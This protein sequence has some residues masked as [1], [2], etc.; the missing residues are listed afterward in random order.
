[1]NTK[2]RPS[3]MDALEPK[4]VWNFFAGISAVPRPSKKEEKI[5][6]YVKELAGSLHLPVR[7]D[8]SGNLCLSVAA[9]PGFEHVPATV[10]QGHLDMVCEK[11]SGTDH[12]F[13]RD[14]IHLVVDE[15]A[16]DGGLFVRAEGTTLGADNGIGVALALAAATSPEV[17]HG[18]LEILCTI[19]EETGMTGAIGL[20]PDFFRGRRMLNLDSD[21]DEILYVGCAGGCDA[22]LHWDLPLRPVAK[23]EEELHIEVS[24]LRGGHSG[25]DVHEDRGNA[26]LLVVRSLLQ[27]AEM[28]PPI[29]D[30]PSASSWPGVMPFRLVSFTGGSKRNAIAR[31]ARAVVAAK[32]GATERLLSV[33]AKLQEETIREAGE[34]ACSI[35]VTK[36]ASANQAGALSAEDSRR[37]LLTLEAVP[38]GVLAIVPEIP[39]LVR[40][41]N[42]VATLLWEAGSGSVS[43]TL[44]CLAR[45][46][47]SVQI[48]Q[49]VDRIFSVGLL[50]GTRVQAGNSYPGWQPRLDSKVLT[51]CTRVYRELFGNDPKI[52]AIHAGLECGIIGER[53][54]GMDMISFGAKITGAHSPD[55]RV[56]VASVQKAWKYLSAVLEA[57]AREA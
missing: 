33:A 56:Y 1:M 55:E 25:G 44:G 42:N 52:T 57:L 5:R 22:T 54:G 24:G 9:S 35:R 50:G 13:D 46:S 19:D 43:L 27:A 21:G 10:I 47:S 28:L 26:I 6:A 3:T 29:G 45:S 8:A 34:P 4:A 39:G 11:N 14:P 15:D 30:A 31:E 23:D 40:T 7:E 18:P 49:A 51:T 38:H 37:V 17:V 53:V 20:Q 41:S 32:T 2:Q 36:G 16:K 48:Q 12:D